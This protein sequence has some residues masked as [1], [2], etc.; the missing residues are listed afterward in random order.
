MKKIFNLLFISLAIILYSSCTPEEDDL[1][2]NSSAQRIEEA[3]RINTEVLT[4]AQNG[5][6][7]EYYPSATQQYGGYTILVSF[8]KNGQTT[9][10]SD[11]FEADRTATSTYVLRQSAGVILSFETYNEV[12]HFFSNPDNPANIGTDGKGMEGD[13]EFNIQK[14]TKDSVVMIGRKTK[15]RIVMTP[16]K[17]DV[18]WKD[19][20]AK[21]Q[22]ADEIYSS[23]VAYEYKE[24]DFKASVKV[25]YRNLSI[26]YNEEEG[27]KTINAPYIIAE[28]GSIKFYE[29]LTL[30]GKTIEGLKYLPNES[31]GTL[32]PT[33]DVNAVFTPKFPLT[34][35]L[36]NNDWYFAMSGLSDPNA[37][38]RW[39]AIKTKIIPKIGPLNYVLFT[40]GGENSLAFYWDCN[41][42]IG[43]LFFDVV[44]TGD[45]QASFAFAYSGN[46]VGVTF[47]NNYY[48][49]Y[50]VYPFMD[51]AFILSADNIENPT[52][53]T[54]TDNS[55]PKNTIKLYKNEI[56][57]PFN[58]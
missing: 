17:Q 3:I 8:N 24:G 14:A 43:Y 11:V 35:W 50:M 57:D 32:I 12:M 44:T 46:S 33:N 58:K 23:F 39:D 52:I 38:E 49:S 36:M 31:K 5:W 48:W 42:V 45:N 19:Y 27:S 25:S 21:I 16:L 15:S 34:Y 51:K 56:L 2:E 47:W 40:S 54:M 9:V 53:I 10:A 18:I 22:D 4:S 29:P 55:N 28:D 30:N 1:F 20:L 7:M 13:F 37:I 41:G 6:L 26:T